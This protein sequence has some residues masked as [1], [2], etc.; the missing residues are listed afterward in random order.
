VYGHVHCGGCSIM[1]M[2]PLGAQSVKCSVCHFVTNVCPHAAW[3]PVSSAP[4]PVQQRPAVPPKSMQTVV[5]ENPPTLDEQGNEVRAMLLQVALFAEVLMQ[6][7][8]SN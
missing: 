3:P 4:G 6:I 8:T 1:L 7:C 2:Y 5:V